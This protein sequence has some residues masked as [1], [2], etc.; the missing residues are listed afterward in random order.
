MLP[1]D[2][3][4]STEVVISR[5]GRQAFTSSKEKPWSAWFHCAPNLS[6]MSPTV[7]LSPS[8]LTLSLGS[9]LHCHR[10]GAALV[11]SSP[12]CY[13]V[14]ALCTRASLVPQLPRLGLGTLFPQQWWARQV[15]AAQWNPGAGSHPGDLLSCI[16][17]LYPPSL[18]FPHFW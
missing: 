4:V 13:C 1:P 14:L 15:T 10:C 8:S 17:L 7:I 12:W 2:S 3:S 5:K 6:D 16:L 18:S 9:G 11:S